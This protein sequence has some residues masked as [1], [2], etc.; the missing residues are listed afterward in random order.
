V[1]WTQA[2]RETLIARDGHT[3]ADGRAGAT[4]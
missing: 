4:L 3:A 1:V 2:G